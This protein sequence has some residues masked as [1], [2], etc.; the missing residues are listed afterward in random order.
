MVN[1]T[2]KKPHHKDLTVV[3][4]AGEHPRITHE[5]IVYYQDARFVYTNLVEQSFLLGVG[6]R[7]SACTPQLLKKVRQGLLTSP[8]IEPDIRA[9]YQG[10]IRV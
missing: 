8:F 5:S 9:Y 4:T 6:S 2:S 1:V 10:R 3:L 7:E